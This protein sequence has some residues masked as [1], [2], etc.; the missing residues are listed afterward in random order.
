MLRQVWVMPSSG[1]VLQRRSRQTQRS[2]VLWLGLVMVCWS[3]KQTGTD[4]VWNVWQGGVAEPFLSPSQEQMLPAVRS[5]DIDRGVPPVETRSNGLESRELGGGDVGCRNTVSPT[6]GT[7]SKILLK[8]YSP[9][10]KWV[11]T[12]FL[13]KFTV[14][15][16]LIQNQWYLNQH[17]TWYKSYLSHF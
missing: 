4:V 17:W 6:T 14:N 12:V 2:M 15:L 3:R 8:N 11:Q 9:K 13:K 7:D 1:R 10:L 5:R 16:V